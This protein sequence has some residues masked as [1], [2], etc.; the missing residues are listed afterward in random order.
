M[1]LYSVNFVGKPK[2]ID[3][4]C[5]YL[6]RRPAP[7]KMNAIGGDAGHGVQKPDIQR[8]IPAGIEN[9]SFTAQRYRMPRGTQRGAYTPAVILFSISQQTRTASINRK[10]INTRG[11]IASQPMLQVFAKLN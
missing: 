3:I 6:R 2:A 11:S 7:M 10:L 9:K 5:M 1:G 4:I 8:V